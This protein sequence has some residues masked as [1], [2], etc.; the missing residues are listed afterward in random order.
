M[1]KI[2]SRYL[3]LSI[4]ALLILCGCSISQFVLPQ[5]SPPKPTTPPPDWFTEWL[6]DPVCQPPCWQGITPGVTTM[7]ETVKILQGL[8]WVTI[9]FGPE[10]LLPNKGEITLE[11]SFIPPSLE[12]GSA[13][14]R[15][16]G[17]INT[18]DVRG[19]LS[20]QLQKVI[21]SYGPPSHVYIPS[22]MDGKCDTRLIY[23]TTGMAVELFLDWEHDAKGD[24]TITPDSE[25]RGID[26]FTPGE[27][28]YLT[29]YPQYSQSFPKWSSPWVGY[30]KYSFM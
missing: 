17:R 6:T 29:G 19:V 4:F 11:W 28:G 3:L 5:L 10:R 22:C 24:V 23:M 14:A 1:A 18:F 26:F 20:T 21:E 16:D 25:V 15:D 27:K 8:P 7:T 12:G 13:Y 30:A 9:D 2:N